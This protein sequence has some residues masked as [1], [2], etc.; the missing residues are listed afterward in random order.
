M[1]EQNQQEQNGKR[2]RTH[3]KRAFK[4]QRL[5]AT[6]KNSWGDV[7]TVADTAEGRSWIEQHAKDGETFRVI[8]VTMEPVAVQVETVEKRSLIEAGA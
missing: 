2:T 1:A 7:A 6:D 3:R 5:S 4:V 8:S